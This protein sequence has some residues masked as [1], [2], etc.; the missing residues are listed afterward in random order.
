[1]VDSSQFDVYGKSFL[2]D[3]IRQDPKARSL[4]TKSM[5]KAR[6]CATADAL[7]RLRTAWFD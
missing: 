5:R 3:H 7:A 2:T 1:M 6:Y 4:Q